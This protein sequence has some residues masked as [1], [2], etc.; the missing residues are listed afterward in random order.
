MRKLLGLALLASLLLNAGLLLHRRRETAPAPVI[1]TRVIEKIVVREAEPGPSSQPPLPAPA[2][3]RRQEIVVPPTV[4]LGSSSGV[5]EP[6]AEL[7]VTCTIVTGSPSSKHWIGLYAVNAPMSTYA[8]Y[9]MV[10]TATPSYG[11]KAPRKPGD[12][13]FRYILED[14]RTAVAV[15]NPV[16]VLGDPPVPPRVELQAGAAVVK[17]G[18]E[19]QGRWSLCSG[20]RSAYDWVGLYPEG[21]KNEDYVAWKYV[22]D[23]QGGVVLKAPEE[24]GT[25]EIRYLLDNGYESVATSVR[26]VVVP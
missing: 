26:I 5:V 10:T 21:A 1:Q 12:Y 20:K 11:F 18:G 15:S 14:N 8:S 19:I 24:P 13:E 23:D 4:A 16:R 3:E 9:R 22:T 2:P 7:T 6:D 17:A 25:Y